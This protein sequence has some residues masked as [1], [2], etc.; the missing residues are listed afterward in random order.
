MIYEKKTL[1]IAPVFIAVVFSI[2]GMTNDYSAIK[3]DEDILFYPT[4]SFEAPGGSV[5]CRIHGH[6]FEKE[7]NSVIRKAITHSIAEALEDEKDED[8]NNPYIDERIRPFL[9]DNEGGKEICIQL[10]GKGYMLPE[11]ESNG[12][13]LSALSLRQMNLKTGNTLSFR[14]ITRLDD[15]RSF[16]GN[17]IFISRTGISVIS[18]IDDTIKDSNV[19]N[20][21]EMIRNTFMR[22]FKAVKGM[23]DFYRKL[24]SRGAVFH[25]VS[26][27]PWQLYQPL[28]GFL[29]DEGFP[30]G[31]VH[32]KYTSSK[33]SSIIDF[34][35]GD[36]VEY[37]VKNIEA[38]MGDLPH[39]KYILI[40]D[41]GESDPEVYTRIAEM[42]KE[43]V[44]AVYVRD[45]NKPG[46]KAERY[47]RLKSMSPGVRFIL[48]KSPSDL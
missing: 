46:D 12:H 36:Q 5:I 3:P 1:L 18:D 6:I 19:L 17:S 30:Y 15:R 37:K 22:K 7:E 32:L 34:V 42:H 44:S 25:Y 41:S 35:K 45:V 40:G 28:S 24:A 23:P 47:S 38:I 14:A 39:R 31:T 11:S 20:K 26:G 27:S 2:S 48:F 13:I 43:K 8:E 16:T 4:Y 29:H 9:Y 21:K 10:D 33:N